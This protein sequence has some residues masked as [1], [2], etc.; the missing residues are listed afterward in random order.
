MNKPLKFNIKLSFTSEILKNNQDNIDISSYIDNLLNKKINIHL[1]I[2]LDKIQQKFNQ[3]KNLFIKYNSNNNS[4]RDIILNNSIA[5]INS[6]DSVIELEKEI[7]PNFIS[8]AQNDETI[9]YKNLS[10]KKITKTTKSTL[11]LDLDE[12]LVYVIDQPN[13]NIT[14]PQI[15]FE[16]YI[17][18][19][20]EINIKKI[21]KNSDIQKI[22]RAKNFIIIRPGFP[23]FIS[24]V[25]KFFDEIL[26]FTSSQYSYAEE[27][28][29]IIDKNKVISKI[30]SRKDCSFYN[31]IF[32]KDL[33]KIKKDLSQTIIIDNYPESYLLQHFNGLPIPSFMGQPK[34]NE[35]LKLLP[36]LEKLSKVKDV[37]NVIREIVSSDGQ[38]VLFNKAHELLKINCEKQINKNLIKNINNKK[39]IATSLNNIKINNNWKKNLKISTLMEKSNNK[40]IEHDS[41]EKIS[42]NEINNYFFIEQDMKH[43]QTIVPSMNKKKNISQRI[44]LNHFDSNDKKKKKKN[45]I[46]DFSGNNRKF[47]FQGNLGKIPQIFNTQSNDNTFDYRKSQD[48]DLNSNINEKNV[49]DFISHNLMLNSAKHIKSK[50]FVNSDMYLLKNKNLYQSHTNSKNKRNKDNLSFM[51]F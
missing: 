17:F 44:S 7:V 46:L 34:D 29:K 35:L 18:D 19:E 28:I 30:Y 32:Y 6:N 12:T 15:P 11:V 51:N 3:K 48:N 49:T 38:T 22:E 23:Q 21:L 37:R 31:D 41:D 40:T 5:E 4:E 24:Q 42:N 9:I 26:V 2:N 10:N 20:N 1:K 14:L 36:I 39:K 47:N 25:K 43:L 45:L 33:N 27:I 50:S 16:Y 13:D 8:G